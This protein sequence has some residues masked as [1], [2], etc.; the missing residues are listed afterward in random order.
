METIEIKGSTVVQAAQSKTLSFKDEAGTTVAE[1]EF[2]NISSHP[3]IVT[4]TEGR[5][6]VLTSL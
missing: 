1:L 6:L 5:V 4:F 3:V 2:R